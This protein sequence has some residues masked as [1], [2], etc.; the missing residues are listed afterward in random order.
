MGL[1]YRIPAQH[2]LVDKKHVEKL[3]M[4]SAYNEM[5]FASEFMG[6]WAGGSEESWFDFEK[7]SKYRTKKIQNLLRNLETSRIVSTLSV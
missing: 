1:D 7:L 2:G 5:T 6:T 3:R 4:S